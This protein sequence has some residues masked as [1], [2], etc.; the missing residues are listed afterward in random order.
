MSTFANLKW[1]DYSTCIYS[2]LQPHISVTRIMSIL[3]ACLA[4]RLL[5][6][7]C[8]CCTA[9]MTQ[10][11]VDSLFPSSTGSVVSN[12]SLIGNPSLPLERSSH[13]MVWWQQ[14]WVC[15]SDQKL[16][17]SSSRHQETACCLKGNGLLKLVVHFTLHNTILT[18][19]LMC[20]TYCSPLG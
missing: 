16:C 1:L 14:M 12:G 4:T 15:P 5:T 20:A 8:H 6:F 17:R 10:W 11:L 9:L 3:R 18:C 2:C 19:H 7:L 13:Q